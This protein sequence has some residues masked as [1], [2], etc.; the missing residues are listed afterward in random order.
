MIKKYSKLDTDEFFDED[1]DLLNS[2]DENN[3][4]DND[5]EYPEV[6]ESLISQ[7]TTQGINK[8]FTLKQIKSSSP[9]ALLKL[10][11]KAKN[12][13]KKDKVWKKICKEYDQ[14]PDIIDYI[15]TMFGDLDVSAKTDHGIIIINYKLLLDGS[16]FK[17]YSYLIHEYTHWFQQC[18]GD[19]PTQSSNQ[20]SYLDNPYEQEGFQNQIEYLSNHFGEDE[21]EEYVD[22]LLK[23]HDIKGK[24]RK[25]ELES[26]L[27]EKVE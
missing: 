21:A 3:V 11:N 25:D 6:G 8:K 9:G 7:G 2:E 17:D 24:K 18:F 16:F 1:F 27:L 12:F 14:D 22:G 4:Q 15:P 20:G 10:I 13:L 26:V 19:K 5:G 23:H